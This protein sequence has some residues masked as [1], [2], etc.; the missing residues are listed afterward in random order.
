MLDESVNRDIYGVTVSNL[1]LMTTLPKN[2]NRTRYRAIGL[3]VGIAGNHYST[4]LF[5]TLATRFGNNAPIAASMIVSRPATGTAVGSVG[6]SG[7]IAQGH[8]LSTKSFPSAAASNTY[9]FFG[10]AA[11]S[12]TDGSS[13]GNNL[14]ANASPGSTTGILG[15]A[16]EA[17]SL[18]GTS[19]YFSS[20]AAFFNPGNGKSWSVAAWA[21]ATNWAT[22]AQTIVDQ[23]SATSDLGFLIQANFSTGGTIDFRATNTASSWDAIISVPQSFANGSWHHVGMSF[24]FATSTLSAYI[25]GKL[26]GTATLANTRSVTSAAFHVGASILSSSFFAGLA[27]SVDECFF[28]NNYALTDNDMRR[29]AAYRYDHNAQ[30][31][32]KNQRWSAKVYPIA[33]GDA[34]QPGAGWLVGASDSNSVFWD[35][36]DLGSTDTVDVILED[37][38]LTPYVQ[39]G[40]QPYD[41]IFTSTLPSSV[42]HGQPDIPEVIVMVED[43]TAGEWAPINTEGKVRAD[44]TNVYFDTTVLPT[45]AASP[46]RVW[47]IA[48]SKRTGAASVPQAT[49][50]RLGTV[51]LGTMTKYNKIVGTGNGA[52]FSTLSGASLTAGDCV[53]INSNVAETAD[54]S[55]PAGVFIDQLPNTVVSLTGA[56][57]NGVRFTGAKSS[58]RNAYVQMNPT[59]TQAKGI[60][61]EANDVQF[62]GIL[63]LNTAQTLTDALNVLSTALRVRAIIDVIKTL[64]TITN[65]ETNNSTGA[66]RTD[67]W[68]G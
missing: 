42:A 48:R 13:N 16:G 8:V 31:A 23:R 4:S 7:Q 27:G 14:T 65:L 49:S 35:F 29:L 43:G 10:L 9:S 34:F 60:S 24:N 25:D 36:S 50:A 53:L 39:T 19:Q 64:G 15:A 66:T 46:N 1:V 5:K 38:G 41:N 52:Q 32:A 59:G 68:G 2:V 17:S 11:G 18:N 56:L 40:V 55:I 63:E 26:V 61:L 12:G 21:T 57:T 58:W 33:D 47:V 44:A 3:V 28:V 30:V 51:F 62:E 6:S 67:V 37:F 20:S 54:L 22:G 45:P